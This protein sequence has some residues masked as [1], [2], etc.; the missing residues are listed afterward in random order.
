MAVFTMENCCS[1]W[2]SL[3]LACRLGWELRERGSDST[4]LGIR[5][6]SWQV[7][8]SPTHSV[9]YSFLKIFS[10]ALISNYWESRKRTFCLLV[11]QCWSGEALR[12]VVKAAAHSGYLRHWF[13]SEEKLVFLF[14]G[15]L[16]MGQKLQGK[17]VWGL[18]AQ[19]IKKKRVKDSY[20]MEGRQ[21]EH[22]GQWGTQ[23][24]SSCSA[25]PEMLINI[26]LVKAR[27][28]RE[29]II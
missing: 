6:F 29:G 26:G 15:I 13:N 22:C 5:V 24:D 10:L 19:R 27:K 3:R 28:R 2:N 14:T 18:F 20:S 16:H 17:S 25:Q 21:C 23:K 9:C 11:F 1:V 4:G 12:K 7:E 8:H